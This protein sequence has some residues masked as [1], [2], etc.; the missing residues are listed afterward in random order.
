MN[1]QN[2]L[3][4]RNKRKNNSFVYST[5]DKTEKNNGI[6]KSQSTIDINNSEKEDSFFPSIQ[7]MSRLEYIKLRKE[8]KI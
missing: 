7:N 2:R 4:R 8:K 6:I 1:K 5:Y 3:K